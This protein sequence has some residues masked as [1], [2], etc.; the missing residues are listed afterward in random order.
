[1]TDFRDE[2]TN[3]A[4]KLYSFDED[5]FISNRP[6][7]TALGDEKYEFVYLSPT[8]DICGVTSASLLEPST[9]VVHHTFTYVGFTHTHIYFIYL[10]SYEQ[11]ANRYREEK[12]VH[13]FSEKESNF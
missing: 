1:M 4:I 11:A 6:F 2:V 3:N 7:G 13:F 10:S 9:S 12:G 8:G 5:T